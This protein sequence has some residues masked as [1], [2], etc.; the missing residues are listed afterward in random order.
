M[1]GGV[2]Y[3]ETEQARRKAYT[4]RKELKRK[5]NVVKEHEEIEKGMM[6]IQRNTNDILH[7]YKSNLKPYMEK[8]RDYILQQVYEKNKDS[9]TLPML[10]RCFGKDFS[11]IVGQPEYSAQE[12]AIVFEYYQECIEKI[13]E[14]RKFPPTRQNFCSFAGIVSSTYDNYL[15]TSDANKKLVMQRIEDYLLENNWTMA[16]LGLLNAYTVEKRT[17]IKGLGGGYTEAR[18]DININ[19]KIVKVESPDDMIKNIENILGK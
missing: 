16:G 13:N 6:A 17:K 18:E 1:A 7:E 2:I 11:N 8:K 14:I 5:A 3:D 12:L 19:S 4:A 15:T 9:V 10:M